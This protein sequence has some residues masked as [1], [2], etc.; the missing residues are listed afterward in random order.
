MSKLLIRRRIDA[1]IINSWGV[2][3]VITLPNKIKSSV[4]PCKNF[5]IELYQKLYQDIKKS[6]L[7]SILATWNFYFSGRY[8][9]KWSYW[10]FMELHNINKNIINLKIFYEICKV[11]RCELKIVCTNTVESIRKIESLPLSCFF[12]QF[13]IFFHRVFF[14]E[15]WSKN[16]LFYL[17]I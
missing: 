15:H 8:F 11:L 13:S 10:Y 1:E 14:T 12:I 4:P 2:I 3:S 6:I 7:I 9:R 16:D 5:K 17:E